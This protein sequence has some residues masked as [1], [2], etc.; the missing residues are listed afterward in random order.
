MQ[1][2]RRLTDD[3][4]E[5]TV[6]ERSRKLFYEGGITEFCIFKREQGAERGKVGP[7]GNSALSEEEISEPFSSAHSSQSSKDQLASRFD[8]KPG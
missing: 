8:L 5:R 6:A 3:M 4:H 1:I 7:S 2:P